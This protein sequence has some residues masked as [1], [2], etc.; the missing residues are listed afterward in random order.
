MT[1]IER[2]RLFPFWR[3]LVFVV[4]RSCP[5][6]KAAAA[7]DLSMTPTM[8]MMMMMMI[9]RPLV[10]R[11][12]AAESEQKQK[13]QQLQLINDENVDAARKKTAKRTQKVMDQVGR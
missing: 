1:H 8:T 2:G 4:M 3:R 9:V 6:A 13:Q 7:A 12:A 10:A 11:P 5:E